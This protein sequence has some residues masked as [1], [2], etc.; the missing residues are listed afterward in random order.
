[1]PGIVLSEDMTHRD[2]RRRALPTTGGRAT[3]TLAA[4]PGDDGNAEEPGEKADRGADTGDGDTGADE[5][6]G[7][8]PPSDVGGGH[9]HSALEDVVQV[10]VTPT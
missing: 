1:M 8:S 6:V 9:G 4:R 3:L 2:A 7:G 5:I 10:T